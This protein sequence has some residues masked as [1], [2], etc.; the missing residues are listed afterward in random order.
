M[1]TSQ[2][3]PAAYAG[4][5][6]LSMLAASIQ[7]ETQNTAP[8]ESQ[9]FIVQLKD[10]QFSAL[11]AQ[12]ISPEALE[13]AKIDL[14]QNVALTVDA[15][16]VRALPSVNSMA[17]LLTAESK[18]ELEANP[19]VAF[20]EVDP[21]RFLMAEDEPYGISMV[22]ANQVSDSMSGNRKVCIVDTG[23]EL[24][25]EDLPSAGITGDDKNGS[26]ST[27]N[28]YE[29]GNGHGTHVAGTIAGIGGNNRGV[30]GVNP[31]NLL[32]LHI[33]KVFNN[34]G[35]WAYG[36]DLVAAVNQCVN[37]GSDVIS[38]SLGGGA[39]S[40]AE[41]QAFANATARNVLSI[42]AAGNDGTSAK[43]YPASYNE[44]VSVAAVDQSGYKAS[45]SQYNDQVEIAAPGVGVN[46]TYIN[47]GYRSLSGTSMAT[48]HVAGVA[49]L[50]W[51]YYPECSGEKVRQAM[52]ATAQDKGAAGRDDRFGHGIVQAKDAL[53]E[54]RR[55]CDDD[56]TDTPP[57]AAFSYSVNGQT[58]TFNNTS[59]DDNGISTNSWNF[60][61]GN[62]SSSV[63]PVHT[64]AE[65]TKYTVKLTVTD[66]VNQSDVA[67]KVV[68]LSTT[69]PPK[70]EEAWSETKSYRSGDKVVYKGNIFE[71][72]WWSTGAQPDVFSNVWKKVGKCDDNGGGDNQA[73][74]ADFGVVVS[75][76]TVTLSDKS[77]DDAGVTSRE[78]SFG[79][80][81]MS[82]QQ[83]PVY[84]YQAAGT[85]NIKLTVKDAQGLT[86]VKSVPVTVG[87]DTTPGCDGVQAWKAGTVYLT[88]ES[89][90][91]KGIK[92]SA[93]WWTQG[94][95]PGTTGQWGVWKNE[96]ACQ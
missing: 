24:G 3:K 6:A 62:T 21:K 76:L 37:A 33:V 5:F 14:L 16:V 67:S 72:T 95:E 52:N 4:A 82:V 43:S 17:L 30:V 91:H 19:D 42:A 31:S 29:D 22:Q 23:Y 51:S 32:K 13:L 46:S 70:C 84:T 68:D 86:G 45:F 93:K 89:V 20:I 83:S 85:Y 73:P 69:T 78:W 88:G 75:G 71:A 12:A 96:G 61:D 49:A 26:N 15:D 9:R 92:Y 38:M 56:P 57:T 54:L 39:S 80:G 50:I 79:D 44:V 81:G 66:T 34:S 25:H 2:I 1:K 94:E 40:N 8:A 87:G 10:S 27:G 28:W 65:K 59:T 7:A 74:V 11:S 41:R 90:S 18:A 58:V 77:S 36:S 63:N 48:P 64:F 55:L 60:G 53:T 47:G 35:N